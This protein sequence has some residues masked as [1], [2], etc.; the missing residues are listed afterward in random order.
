M[1][2]TKSML[3]AVR[4]KLVESQAALC[5]TLAAG[6]GDALWAEHQRRFPYFVGG[7]PERNEELLRQLLYDDLT[8]A[9]PH[10]L[11]D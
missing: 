1:R 6:G 2:I 9:I 3:K 11:V 4:T 10:H 7:R 5:A 8:R